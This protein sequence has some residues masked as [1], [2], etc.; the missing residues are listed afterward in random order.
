MGEA[1]YEFTN[2]QFFNLLEDQNPK[3]MKLINSIGGRGS[4]SHNSDSPPL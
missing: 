4:Y 3:V 2:L 1:L